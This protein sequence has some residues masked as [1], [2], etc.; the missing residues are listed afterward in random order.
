MGGACGSSKM[1]ACGCV[2]TW[3]QVR[4]G[5]LDHTARPPVPDQEAGGRCTFTNRVVKTVI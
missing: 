4:A 3:W 5:V 1:S 2:C